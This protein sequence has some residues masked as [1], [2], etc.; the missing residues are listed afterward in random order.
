MKR[1]FTMI[2]VGLLIGVLLAGC[3][4]STGALTRVRIATDPTYPPFE[5]VQR[6]N[7][8]LVGFD[9]DVMRAIADRAGLNVEFVSTSYDILL[10]SVARCE[11]DGA[12]SAMEITDDLKQSMSFSNPYYVVGQEV[13]VKKGNL[14]ITGRDTLAGMVVG[15]QKGQT[16]AAE[17]QKMA[18]VQ[19]RLYDS[20]EMAFQDLI[21]GLIDAVV[22]DSPQAQDYSSLPA[23]NLKIVGSSFTPKNYGIAV[24]NQNPDLLK[25]IN[26]G[27]ATIQSDGTLER[28]RQKWIVQGVQ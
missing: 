25:K 11:V 20:A 17:L 18:G 4:S 26:T 1:F 7:K 9:M 14:S 3:A 22:A 10:G 23:N 5:Q 27:L 12:I 24:C 8:Q 21:I 28:L 6:E 19:T 16:G 15:A 2:G 13:V